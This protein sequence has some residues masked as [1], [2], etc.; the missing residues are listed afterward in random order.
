MDTGHSIRPEPFLRSPITSGNSKKICWPKNNLHL[1][2]LMID[3]QSL[4]SVTP[5]PKEEPDHDNISQMS[6]Q[7]VYSHGKSIFRSMRQRVKKIR[8]KGS[9]KGGFPMDLKSMSSPPSISLSLSSASSFSTTASSYST[10][11]KLKHKF[12]DH[13]YLFE[14]DELIKFVSSHDCSFGKVVQIKGRLII[15]N[16]AIFFSGSF[17]NRKIRVIDA[18]FSS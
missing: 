16:K 8:R 14:Q 9:S 17:I 10:I 5:G 7:S 18:I 4:P 11:E 1:A 13:K 12:E 2:K 15:T 3:R 6:G